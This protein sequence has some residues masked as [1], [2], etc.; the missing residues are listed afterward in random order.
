M[1]KFGR[2]PLVTLRRFL[3]GGAKNISPADVGH[4]IRQGFAQIGH[5]MVIGYENIKLGISNWRSRVLTPGFTLL[6]LLRL[7]L[8]IAGTIYLSRIFNGSYSIVAFCLCL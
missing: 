2:N 1:L 5:G 7:A 3:S 8:V 6:L 4:A